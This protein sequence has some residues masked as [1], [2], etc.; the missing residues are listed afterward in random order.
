MTTEERCFY[1]VWN[2]NG[3]APMKKH[4]SKRD[5]ETEAG[6]LARQNQGQTFVVLKSISEHVACDVK[7][8]RHCDYAED[9]PF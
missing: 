9:R 2:P 8:T 3:R 4:P 6:R 7:V 1:V 5:A